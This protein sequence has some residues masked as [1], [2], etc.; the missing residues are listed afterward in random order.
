MVAASAV[1]EASL[2]TDQLND[3]KNAALSIISV[4]IA[5]LST[6]SVARP[7]LSLFSVGMAG[8]VYYLGYDGWS[9]PFSPQT[10]AVL[11]TISVSVV[12]TAH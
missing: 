1:L 8:S 10:R 5:M 6:F 2:G 7:V 12:G 9:N 3:Q 11:S 4:L